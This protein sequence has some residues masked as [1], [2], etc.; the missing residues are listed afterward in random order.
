M[1]EKN[2][3]LSQNDVCIAKKL[4]NYINKEVES[5]IHQLRCRLTKSSMRQKKNL[6]PI[7]L[8]VTPGIK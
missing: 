6:Q 4:S 1:T 3:A 8:S 2:V 7:I 5:H